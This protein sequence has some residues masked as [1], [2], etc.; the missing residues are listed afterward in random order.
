LALHTFIDLLEAAARYQDDFGRWSLTVREGLDEAG[1][2][3]EDESETKLDENVG[4]DQPPS[5]R[6]L[7]LALAFGYVLRAKAEGWKLF[8][9]RLNISPFLLWETLP[10]F[11]RLQRALALAERIAFVPE[12]FLRWLNRIRPKGAP[13]LT[14]VR[15]TA[16]AMADANEASFR[17]RIRWLGG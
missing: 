4:H 5:Q 16:E 2:D 6:Y 7:D 12:G 13:E 15:L 8:C 10:G 3:L 17:E 1:E 11:D 9:E 14:E